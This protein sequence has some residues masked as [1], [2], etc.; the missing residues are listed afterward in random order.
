[1]SVNDAI[2]LVDSCWSFEGVEP[3]VLA[4]PLKAQETFAPCKLQDKHKFQVRLA[5]W[6][7]RVVGADVSSPNKV[8]EK[9]V[10]EQVWKI[11]YETQVKSINT[12]DYSF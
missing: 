6:D 3:D 1:M 5:V 4:A 10:A 2:K 7:G 11:S 9:C 8:L 12:I